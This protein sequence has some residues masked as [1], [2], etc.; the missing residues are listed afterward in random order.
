MALNTAG[1]TKSV[2]DNGLDLTLQNNLTATSAPTVNDDITTGYSVGSHWINVTGDTIYVCV[3]NTDGAAVWD[4]VDA[5]GAASSD[6]GSASGD[7]YWA[8]T[9]TTVATPAVVGGTGAGQLAIGDGAV[10][11]G[12][13]ANQTVLGYQAYASG[14]NSIAI[15]TGNNGGSYGALATGA[16]AIGDISVASGSNGVAIGYGATLSVASAV[17][18]GSTAICDGSQSVVIGYAAHVYTGASYNVVIGASASVLASKTY[19]VV[20]GYTAQSSGSQNVCVGHVAKASGDYN[21]NIG[22]NANTINGSNC[23]QIGYNASTS[24]KT[25][26]VA[27]GNGITVANSY[28]IAIGSSAV[29]LEVVNGVLQLT[30]T[31]AQYKAPSYALASLPT[32][33]TGG[34]I[35]VSDASR[36]PSGT[37]TLAFFDGANWIDVTTGATVD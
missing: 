37:G 32:G 35:Y 8:A 28:D 18:I 17:S 6:W 30:A 2:N 19:N 4:Q 27:I 13:A 10:I 36:S 7:A 5:S 16:I 34:L 26:A 11:N 22:Y 1:N 9:P 14:F 21:V 3:D 31:N 15:G 20:I 29:K 12:T 25:Y 24:N 23:I 33:Q